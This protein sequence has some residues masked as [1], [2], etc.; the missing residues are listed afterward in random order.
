MLSEMYGD[1]PQSAPSSPER[2]CPGANVADAGSASAGDESA[3][4]DSTNQR[5]SG[6]DE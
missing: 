2:S 5:K 3:E 6:E 4:A 1:D